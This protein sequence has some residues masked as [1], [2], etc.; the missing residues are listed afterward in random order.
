MMPPL[1]AEPATRDIRV[2]VAVTRLAWTPATSTE[3]PAE[4]AATGAAPLART[5]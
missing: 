5:V 2:S 4:D 3:P 1:A